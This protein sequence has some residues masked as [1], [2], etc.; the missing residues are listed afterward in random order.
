MLFPPPPPKLQ[1]RLFEAKL[2]HF[3]IKGGAEDKDLNFYINVTSKICSNFGIKIIHINGFDFELKV[4]Q[5]LAKKFNLVIVQQ[6]H[7]YE[8][9]DYDLCYYSI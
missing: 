9:F 2:P 7:S 1:N 3:A 8:V 4:A 6:Y 5:A